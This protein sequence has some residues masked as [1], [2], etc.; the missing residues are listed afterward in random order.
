MIMGKKSLWV[1]PFLPIHPLHLWTGHALYHF[2]KGRQMDGY[3]GRWRDS[4]LPTHPVSAAATSSTHLPPL[5]T[6]RPPLLAATSTFPSPQVFTLRFCARGRGNVPLNVPLDNC[7]TSKEGFVHLSFTFPITT[8][9]ELS[10][11][12]K[13]VAFLLCIY[14]YLLW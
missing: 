10:P 9:R 14:W 7:L 2:Q 5:A 1:I 3:L 4:P 13:T 6:E 12:R 11:Q 8:R